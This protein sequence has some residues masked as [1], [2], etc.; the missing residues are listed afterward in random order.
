[1]AEEEL[2]A[3]VAAPAEAGEAAEKKPVRR[4]TTRKAVDA[5]VPAEAPAAEAEKPAR[6]RGRP[7]KADVEAA[8]QAADE[9]TPAP[10]ADAEKPARRRGRPRK[11]D[12]EAAAAAEEAKQ[13]PAAPAGQAEVAKPAK[14]DAAAAEKPAKPEAKAEGKQDEKASAGE[15]KQQRQ[16][17]SHQQQ[18]GRRRN[19]R[20]K[21]Q[22]NNRNRNQV[23]EPKTNKDEL[24]AMKVAEL[25][26]KAA[27]LDLDVKGML[28][29]D[30]VEA[31]FQALV[32]KEGFREVAGILDILPDGYGFVRTKGYLPGEGD[33]YVN[34]SMIRRNHLRKGD[35]ITGQMRPAR[36][37][38]KFGAVQRLD[39]VNGKS[40]EELGNRVKFA[41]LT[42]VFPDER[43]V[44]EHGKNTT[45]A[46]VI[47][48]TA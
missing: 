12:V 29:A 2:N 45:T 38:E 6:R 43:L 21:F 5:E 30:L 1:M 39:T 44:M 4:R 48:L 35:W 24:A 19:R 36:E 11:A 42:P 25:R 8:K 13:A 9:A 14:E 17:D 27:E 23:V 31:V 26:E 32:K 41:D 46:R 18:G 15:S 10:A 40:P 33:A 16:Q 7:R 22:R 34:Q 20:E 37:N 47:D 3:Q 28:K